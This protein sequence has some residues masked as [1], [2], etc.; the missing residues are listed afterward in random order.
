LGVGAGFAAGAGLGYL[1][2]PG[3]YGNIPYSVRGDYYSD[4]QN[5]Y[6]ALPAYPNAPNGDP[7]M[8]P[9]Q[10]GSETG[11]Q[12]TEVMDGPAKKADLRVGDIILGIGQTRTQTFEELQDA[13]AASKGKVE[14][15]FI[16]HESKNVEKLPITPV[17]SKL[18]VAVVH[19]AVR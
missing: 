4:G 6:S 7:S 8:Y 19:A 14:I 12:I 17:D 3:G 10:T 18:G 9:Q 13:L 2:A 15:V 1:F 16:N 11:M 5:G